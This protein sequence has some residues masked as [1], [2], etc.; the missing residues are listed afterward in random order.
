MSIFLGGTASANE[1]HD[2]ETGNW[3]PS[4]PNGGSYSNIYGKYVKMGRL[5]FVNY[6]MNTIIPPSNGNGFYIGGLPFQCNGTSHG[7]GNFSYTGG[8]GMSAVN[9]MPIVATYS[10]YI[11]FHRQDG[12]TA[13]WNNSQQ[14][15]TNYNQP[16]IAGVLYETDS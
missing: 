13:V 1:F 16:H 7:F 2:Y 3:T 14:R 8:T 10:T 11:Y 6:Y 4:L 12:T 5:V 15:S 9:L